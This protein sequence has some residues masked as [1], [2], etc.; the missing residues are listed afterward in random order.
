MNLKLFKAKAR[1]SSIEYKCELKLGI[2]QLSNL[3]QNINKENDH[4]KEMVWLPFQ[5]RIFQ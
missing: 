3:L 2:G 5:K 4:Y 1:P